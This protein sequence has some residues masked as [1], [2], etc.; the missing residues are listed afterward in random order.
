M[1]VTKWMIPLALLVTVTGCRKTP[2]EQ[3]PENNRAEKMAKISEGDQ[4]LLAKEGDPVI[5]GRKRQIPFTVENLRKAVALATQRKKT[6]EQQ[7]GRTN[8]TDL[9][10]PPDENPP[11]GGGGGPQPNYYYVRFL[12]A[13]VEQLNKLEEDNGFDL[14]DVPLNYDI[15]QE[16]DWYQDPSLNPDAITW[17]YTLVP[18][19]YPMPPEITREIIAPLFLF[20][21]DAGEEMEPED[22][23]GGDGT[24]ERTG[25]NVNI[26]NI[27]PV[28]EWITAHG[29][30]LKAARK[31]LQQSYPDLSLT[32]I[33]DALMEV[34]D[35][36]DEMTDTE[37]PLA[38]G[39]RYKPEGN[40]RVRNTNLGI[41]EP[42]PG[43]L[44][45]SRNFFKLGHAYT[46]FSGHFFI[47]KGYKRRAQIIV[48]F[49]NG[50]VKTRGINGALKVWQYSFPVKHKM[51]RFIRN[52]MRAI[53][54]EFVNDGQPHSE[55]TRKWAAATF[56]NG[57]F[58]FDREMG[59]LQSGTFPQVKVWLSS[60]I[61][62][63]ASTPMLTYVLAPGT[64]SPEA[65]AE[66]SLISSG[67]DRI[68]Q[69]VPYVGLAL[70]T[71]KRVVELNKPDLTLRYNDG[72]II[73]NSANFYGTTYHELSHAAHYAQLLAAQ[74]IMGASNYW[75]GNIKYVVQHGGYGEK[76][77]NNYER[78]AII[79]SWGFFSGSFLNARKFDVFA[80][81]VAA[82]IA[83]AE[84]RFIENQEPVEDVDV[85]DAADLNGTGINGSRG[86]IPYGM[87]NDLMDIGEQ[88]NATNVADGV[89]DFGYRQCFLPLQPNVITVRG[90][91]QQF[92]LTNGNAQGVQIND[93]VGDYLY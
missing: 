26:G 47:N 50:R 46:D 59:N 37:N 36:K 15:A 70:E 68:L 25:V 71:L 52:D 66:Y 54:F 20:D 81:P 65:I 34:S 12:P 45:K 87:H 79:E 82:D 3:L 1:R 74:P 89:Q 80:N 44:V 28:R 72:N 64:G 27:S 92:L 78:C 53:N 39:P 32:E 29:S 67:V 63:D 56:M 69:F 73:R 13:D 83:D 31:Y 21:D 43:V 8:A 40:L 49:K 58:E 9:M 16:G 2:D 18:V 61:T 11:G 55:V 76:F 75:W 85:E 24:P 86:W 88:V 35:N 17:Q 19:G 7:N 33:H 22:E 30:P 10:I 57:A 48:K 42:L 77:D 23:W 90:Y 38:R 6:A 14:W 84:R 5:L 51:G 41:P 4:T 91:M 93:L 60:R 62:S